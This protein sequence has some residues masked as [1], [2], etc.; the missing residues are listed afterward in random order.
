MPFCFRGFNGRVVFG[1][2]CANFGSC[3]LKAIMGSLKRTYNVA[4]TFP[5]CLKV[6]ELTILGLAKRVGHIVLIVMRKDVI[7]LVVG[8][9]SV[10]QGTCF[11]GLH[12][13]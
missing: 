3:S 2:T 6:V 13:A 10:L 9:R 12:R 1:Y 5:N 11:W 8:S 4:L 7:D